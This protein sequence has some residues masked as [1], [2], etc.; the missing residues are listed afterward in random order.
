MG[1]CFQNIASNIGK[2]DD[3]AETPREEKS[4]N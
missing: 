4:K 2:K 1:R 3:G